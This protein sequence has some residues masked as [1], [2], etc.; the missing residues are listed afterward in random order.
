M[1]TDMLCGKRRNPTVTELFTIDKTLNIF[2]VFITQCCFAATKNARLNPMYYF[3]MK[4]L[5]KRK[6][7]EIAINYS[8]D[9]DFKH[10]MNL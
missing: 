1:I 5:N 4:I 7:Q 9:T 3:I 10:F 2:L 6:R 8:S